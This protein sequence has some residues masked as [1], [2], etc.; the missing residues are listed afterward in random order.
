MRCPYGEVAQ[1]RPV[2]L[3]VVLVYFAS[4]VWQRRQIAADE[5][6][7]RLVEWNESQSWYLHI[8]KFGKVVA[9]E[10]GQLSAHG[11]HC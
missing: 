10:I 7:Q 6:L 1:Q 8:R 2:L 11:L 9:D 3:D 4:Q 5:R